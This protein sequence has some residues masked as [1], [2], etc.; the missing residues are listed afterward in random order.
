MPSAHYE[1]VEDRQTYYNPC[2]VSDL[3]FV[4][5]NDWQLTDK[6]RQ[7]FPILC[8]VVIEERTWFM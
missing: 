7:T 4:T 5:T 3:Y 1:R 8:A 6:L 2:V